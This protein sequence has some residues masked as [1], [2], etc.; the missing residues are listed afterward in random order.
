MENLMR[1]N[2]FHTVWGLVLIF[3][4]VPATAQESP[5]LINIPLTNPGESIFLE[6]SILSARIEVIGED[7]DDVEIEVS[8]VDSERKIITPSGAK[9]FRNRGYSLQ[10]N[11]HNNRITI[12]TDWRA[13]KVTVVVRIPRLADLDLSTVNDGEIIVSDISGDL[14]LSN[15]NGPITANRIS[16]SV[17]AESVNE[18]ID[19]GF[20][21]IDD[22]KATSLESINGDLYLRLPTGTGAQI[23][24]DTARGEITSDFEVELQPAKQ[25]IERDEHQGG[26]A[27]RI[28]SVI[29]AD[30]NGGGRI[31]RLKSLHGDI[32][33]SEI[34]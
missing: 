15:T 4:M 31:I 22:N 14:E 8:I 13:N 21:D 34:R 17:I 1:S 25:S 2:F 5:Q 9:P 19:I 7:R 16:G 3:C 33:I 23:H 28:E 11:E 18:T 29:V 30:I 10:V 12:G 6:I 20:V 32:H 27:I 24:L 26:V